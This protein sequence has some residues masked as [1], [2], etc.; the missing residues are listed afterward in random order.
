MFFDSKLLVIA[1][2]TSDERQ[3]QQGCGHHRQERAGN[4]LRMC[5]HFVLLCQPVG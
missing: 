5:R 3:H 1:I 4:I 2:P